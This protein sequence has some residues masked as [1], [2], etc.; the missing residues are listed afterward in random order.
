MLARRK[1][2]MSWSTE[3]SLTNQD[4]SDCTKGW[5]HLLG[6][7][8]KDLHSWT[9]FVLA[10]F[11]GQSALPTPWEE[12]TQIIDLCYCVEQLVD[13]P[14]MTFPSC[15]CCGRSCSSWM[16]YN[17]SGL[18]RLWRGQNPDG[19]HPKQPAFMSLC[20]W[21]YCYQKNLVWSPFG[22]NFYLRQS[23]A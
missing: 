2:G 9:S 6:D 18:L 7:L 20:S 10:S 16:C 22:P 17:S 21:S 8:K 5:N 4:V 3:F 13:L 14:L 19:S 15:Y 1:A 11:M 23:S 12:T